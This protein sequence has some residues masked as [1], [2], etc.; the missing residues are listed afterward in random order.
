[1]RTI[2]SVWSACGPSPQ[3]R[4][5]TEALHTFF[6]Q[7]GKTT[8]ILPVPGLILAKGPAPTLFGPHVNQGQEGSRFVNLCVFFLFIC[9]KVGSPPAATLLSALSTITDP[10]LTINP[11][12]YHLFF[13]LQTLACPGQGL[14]IIREGCLSC[15]QGDSVNISF[16]L[17]TQ[18]VFISKQNLD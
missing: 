1:M 15:F 12:K 9:L 17:T 11:I 16:H 3:L 7:K 6:T 8:L 10:W 4:T 5:F 2:S 13:L 18:F 14:R